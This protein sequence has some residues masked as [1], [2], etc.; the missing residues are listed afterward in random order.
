MTK[1]VNTIRYRKYALIV[2]KIKTERKG[3]QMKAIEILKQLNVTTDGTNKDIEDALEELEHMWKVIN[4]KV[5]ESELRQMVE[6]HNPA[7][8]FVDVSEIKDMSYL[9]KNSDFGGSWTADISGWDTSNVANMGYM[10]QD[11]KNL[12]EVSL[13]HTGKV[14]YMSFMFDGCKN[15]TEVSLP[16]TE[17]VKNMYVMFR[18]CT[19]LHQ[20][21]SN[22]NVETVLDIFMFDG[23][24]KMEESYKKGN[25]L[26]PKGYKQCQNA[27]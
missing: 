7:I 3:N 24:T 20:D 4:R 19:A 8:E 11:C 2:V 15:L 16:H 27:Y 13:P 10:F 1:S 6:N 21:F 14:T 25:N 22:W 17:N 26:Y 18:G 5:D 12:E 23:C 9:F